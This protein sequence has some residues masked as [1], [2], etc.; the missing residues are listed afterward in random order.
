MK[1]FGYIRVNPSDYVIVFQNGKIIKEGRGLSFFKRRSIQYVII[2]A[3]VSNITFTADQV[4]IENQGVEV[5]GFAIWKIG[6]PSKIYLHFNFSKENNPAEKIS[7]FLRDVV[8]SAIRHMVANMTI[9]DV[10]R[11]RGSIILQLKKE[12]EYISNQW[13]IIIET[14]EIKNVKIL[15]SQLFSNMQAKYRN[16]IRTESETSTLKTEQEITEQ[17]LLQKEKL[18]LLE[19]ESKRA[20]LERKKEMDTLVL[21]QNSELS[22]LNI[23]DEKNEK[24][25]QMANDLELYA[26]QEDNKRKMAALQLETIQAQESLERLKAEIELI[27]K[28]T[29][30]DFKKLDISIEHDIMELS[31]LEDTQKILFRK[32][33]E[34]AAALKISTLSLG[35]DDIH[36]LIDSIM[37]KLN[38]K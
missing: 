15:S 5:S 38:A 23:D 24:M 7:A 16:A 21:K 8:E 4:T 36:K 1:N 33:P 35:T 14:I 26:K 2:P 17:R 6:E 10:L 25:V 3:M 32:L 27:K 29:E 34:I 12:L 13:G 11:K 20:E 28:Q 9:E 37:K 19:Q 22:R 30:I 31:N 18:G